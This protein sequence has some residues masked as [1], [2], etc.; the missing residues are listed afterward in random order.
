MAENSKYINID[1][2]FQD[3]KEG[4]FLNLN[5]VDSKAIRAD[6]MHLLLTRRGE[7]LYNPEFG[8]DLMRFIF[9][10]NDNLTYSDIKLDIQTT[11]KKYIPN[12]NVDN[13][14]VETS[15]ENEY[16][17]NVRIDYTITDDVFK[18]TDFIIITI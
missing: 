9:E 2:P 10:P 6:L 16:K 18:E 12:L 11:V 13:I 1:F 5:N 3:S 14:T 8:T 4:F 15:E 7:R 17:A